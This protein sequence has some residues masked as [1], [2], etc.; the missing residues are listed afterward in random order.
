MELLMD[1]MKQK[2]RG[3]IKMTLVE[4][5]YVDIDINEIIETMKDEDFL[6]DYKEFIEEPDDL[7]YYATRDYICGLDD[8]EYNIAF[9]HLYE[10]K[11]EVARVLKERE[12]K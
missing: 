11:N 6:S 2:E 8:I 5:V 9:S 3:V 4:T 1:T 10:I 12:E 7:I